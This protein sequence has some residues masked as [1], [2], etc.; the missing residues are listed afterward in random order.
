VSDR[1][2]KLLTVSSEAAK[3]IR[4]TNLDAMR[5]NKITTTAAAIDGIASIA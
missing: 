1:K 5:V 4:R 3:L 2:D